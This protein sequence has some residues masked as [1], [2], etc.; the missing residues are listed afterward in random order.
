MKPQYI[1]PCLESA[2]D[3]WW[4]YNVDDDRKDYFS[5]NYY[6]FHI[7]PIQRCEQCWRWSEGLLGCLIPPRSIPPISHSCSTSS[8]RPLP[9]SSLATWWRWW[10]WWAIKLCG[11]ESFCQRTGL[12]IQSEWLCWENTNRK[13]TWLSLRSSWS[14]SCW[15]DGRKIE[16]QAPAMQLVGFSHGQ[17]QG[18]VAL[19]AQISRSSQS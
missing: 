9:P 7:F 15:A 11:N 5:T 1:F 13:T 8:L 18:C 2:P 19:L 3:Q 17:S 16:A 6:F 10:W 14:W 4:S 12:I